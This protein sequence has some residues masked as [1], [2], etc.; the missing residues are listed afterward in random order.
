MAT[1][2]KKTPEKEAE[3]EGVVATPEK[4]TVLE[5][6]L[7]PEILKLIEGLVADG[8]AKKL[9]EDKV[10]SVGTVRSDKGGEIANA[11]AY[12][13]EMVTIRLHKDGDRYKD[14]VFVGWNGVGYQIQ[15]GVNVDVPRGVKLILDQSL[16]T[17]ERTA[18]LISEKEARFE[19][20]SL[21]RG[22]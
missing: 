22:R 2:E 9:S 11:E 6:A 8:V 15:R 3:Q 14:D 13:K 4:E 7:T 12:L 1:K 17:D 19:R 20:E 10:K 16:A 21:T 5:T 18:T